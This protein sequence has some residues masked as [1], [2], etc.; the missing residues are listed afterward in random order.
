MVQIKNKKYF[1]IKSKNK[2]I[3]N[4][5]SI[6]LKIN[7]FTIHIIKISPFNNTMN[8]GYISVYKKA[9][10]NLP[11]TNISD[12][13]D[14]EKVASEIINEGVIRPVITSRV[15]VDPTKPV[16]DYAPFSPMA[17]DN[18]LHSFAHKEA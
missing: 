17:K 9:S 16:N 4:H 2:K 15:L 11:I 10:H 3:N 6:F 14:E 7:I 12:T 1:K 8:V 13:Y 18:W 5:S